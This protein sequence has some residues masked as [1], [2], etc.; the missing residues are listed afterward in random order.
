MVSNIAENIVIYDWLSF[1]SKQLS[2]DQIIS[3]LGLSHLPWVE[4]KGSRGYKR[5]KYYSSINIH[6]DGR[7][8]MGVWCEMSGQ[9]C[10]SFETLSKLFLDGDGWVRLFRWITENECKL[11]RLDVAYDDHSGILPVG[12]IVQDTQ[13]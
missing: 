7:D 4:T 12:D 11:T 13:C 8:D 3:A 10:R 6:Y 5:K 9:G 2:P 1:T